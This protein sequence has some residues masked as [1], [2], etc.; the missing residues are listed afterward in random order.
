VTSER[1]YSAINGAWSSHIRISGSI[2]IPVSE[3]HLLTASS[4]IPENEGTAA[5]Q[6]E[7]TED[8]LYSLHLA[9]S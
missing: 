4:V 5:V 1:D 6:S 3:I 8:C 7:K 2:Q 9:L